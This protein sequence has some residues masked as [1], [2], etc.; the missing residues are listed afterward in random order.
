MASTHPTLHNSNLC[1]PASNPTRAHLHVVEDQVPKDQ[2]AN[3]LAGLAAVS[4][5]LRQNLPLV[6]FPLK[7]GV[8]VGVVMP[9]EFVNSVESQVYA[10]ERF[11]ES[12]LQ[13]LGFVCG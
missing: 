9:C 11:C 10:H 4:Q 7:S 2:Q 6:S 5:V 13:A 12:L 8:G 3:L 1:P